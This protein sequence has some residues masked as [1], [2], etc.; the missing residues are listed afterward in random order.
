MNGYFGEEGSMPDRTPEQHSKEIFY[1]TGTV[2]TVDGAVTATTT[3]AAAATDAFGRQRTADPEALFDDSF[4]YEI[5]D[6]FWDT[7]TTGG[8]DIQHDATN[9]VASLTVSGSTA[10]TAI[11]QTLAYHP[12]QKGKSQRAIPTFVLGAVATGITRRVGYFDGDDGVFLE[13][14]SAGFKL[15]QRSSTDSD[16]ETSQ[17][18]WSEDP[19]DGSGAS[20]IDLDPTKRLIL[21]MDIEWLGAGRVR[22]GFNV[23]GNTIYAH[24]NNNAN[25]GGAA[26]YM[27]TGTLPIRYE[28]VNDGTGAASELKGICAA[29]FSEGGFDQG[30]GMP[31]SADRKVIAASVGARVPV[32]SIRPKST[33]NSIV[34]RGRITPQSVSILTVSQSVLVEVVRGGLLFGTGSFVSADSNS[35]AD[36]NFSFTSISGGHTVQSFMVST[37]GAGGNARG[38][39]NSP[40]LSRLPLT[41][42]IDGNNP[43]PLSVVCTPITPTATVYPTINWEEVR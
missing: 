9:R 40:I 7:K 28:I 39:G 32:L 22:Y 16:I 27:R 38:E 26:P 31:F 35:I 8:G 19:M 10:G 11:L 25:A 43:I 30:R 15:V 12:Y 37:A 18:I 5:N 1:A 33:F 4:E 20:G 24:F 2:V 21:D 36:Y 29:V 34:N 13:Q 14:T 42:D 17:A 6:L 3:Q 41:L 23:D